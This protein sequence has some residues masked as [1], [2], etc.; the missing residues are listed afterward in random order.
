MYSLN[1]KL[2]LITGAA[3]GLGLAAAEAFAKAGASL[4][5]VDYSDQLASVTSQVKA[6]M[7]SN[8]QATIESYKVDVTNSTQIKNLFDSIRE[9]HP[10]SAPNVIV[11]S[12]GIARLS[13]ILEMSEKDF[14][15]TMNIN[16]KGTFLITQAATRA[17]V[18][19]F[20]SVKFSSPLETYASIINLSSQA[21]KLPAERSSHYSSSKAAV[22]A[23]SRST[24]REFGKYRIR[25]NAVLPYFIETPMINVLNNKEKDFYARL[26]ALGRLGKPDE[27]A[28]LILFLA[29][30]QSSYINGA[31]IDIHG[32]M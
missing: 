31:A 25:C 14:D 6:K 12:A 24:M 7:K 30:D 15:D 27:V 21:S 32:G 3:S 11:N 2:A 18:D 8:K 16:L 26:T 13:T 28:N 4:I 9:K 1:S 20:P 5:L 17:L 22:V 19:K 29:S 23:F 10:I